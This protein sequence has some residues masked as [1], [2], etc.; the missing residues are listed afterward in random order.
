MA[1]NTGR[2]VF[3]RYGKFYVDNAAGTLTELA[4]STVNGVGMTYGEK[5][6]FATLDAVKGKLLETPDCKID[7]T[8]P[9]DTT[10]HTVLTG[11]YGLQSV[12]LALDVRLGIR[13]TWESGEPTFG[14]TGSATNGFYCSSYVVDWA[15]G[16]YSASFV[17]ASGSAAPEW[18]TTAHT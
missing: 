7:I 2:S 11:I 16:T 17:V 6:M 1:A 13:H 14:I 8:G 9:F 12:P 3:S 5:E 15:N 4:V 18:A 10:T